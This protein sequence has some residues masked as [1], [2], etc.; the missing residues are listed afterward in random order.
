MHEIPP[1]S[2][3]WQLGSQLPG[4]RPPRPA[5]L[6]PGSHVG[7]Y[8]LGDLLG[9]GASGQVFRARGAAGDVALKLLRADASDAARARFLRE[10]RLV[11]ALRHPGI[12]SLHDA[13][14]ADG[15]AYL[16]CELVP[17]GR[18]LDTAWRVLPL[19]DRVRLLRDVALAVEHAHAA[20]ILHRDL[21]PANV[22]VDTEGQPRVIDF[23]VGVA[24]DTERL[25]LSGA[26]V[27]TP[28]YM[29]PEQALGGRDAVSPASDVWSLGVM[30]YEA[31]TDS[32]PL[33]GET[34]PEQV[35]LLEG[36]AIERP[37]ARTPDVPAQLE[38]ICLRALSRDPGARY[39]SAAALAAALDGWLSPS[40]ARRVGLLGAALVGVAFAVGLLLR[41]GANGATVA[42]SPSPSA[43]PQVAAVAGSPLP[44]GGAAT[45]SRSPVA[46]AQ[47][48]AGLEAW[49]DQL[50]VCARLGDWAAIPAVLDAYAGERPAEVV[51]RFELESLRIGWRKCEALLRRRSG[52]SYARGWVAFVCQDFEEAE[53]YAEEACAQ[54]PEQSDPWLLLA[55]TRGARD[56]HQG[57]LGAVEECLRQHPQRVEALRIKVGLLQS[58]GEYARALEVADK[59]LTIASDSDAWFQRGYL[60]AR[61]GDSSGAREDFARALELAPPTGGRLRALGGKAANELWRVGAQ[62]AASFLIDELLSRYPEDR[63]VRMTRAVFRAESG[64]LAQARDD[65]DLILREG[66]PPLTRGRAL[67]MRG[68]LNL[69]LGDVEA[70]QRDL[71]ASLQVAPGADFEKAT[72]E[73]LRQVEAQLG[74]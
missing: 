42:P 44:A 68:R 17:R 23:G 58:M 21:K 70:A 41:A 59:Q 13:G 20:G 38:A 16:A 50:R 72:R 47:A 55:A 37:R 43:S 7:P 19:R 30:L 24:A 26:L 53:T 4:P 27:G 61:L 8:V 25:T 34:L 40:P 65:L 66:T 51:H 57:A 14:E 2:V 6:S 1:E 67:S 5:S 46:P 73:Q 10:G 71:L 63:L 69:E 3:D 74:R 64:Q 39:A 35:A 11:A 22:L 60:R 45:P 49:R 56:D 9:R 29:A 62:E 32:L 12:V 48:R 33:H 36:G 18:P 15:W 31:L 52:P 28:F 54:E